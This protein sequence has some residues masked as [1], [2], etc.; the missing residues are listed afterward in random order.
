MFVTHSVY[1][2]AYLSSRIAVMSARPGCIVAEI[3][4]ESPGPRAKDFRTS[5]R[6]AQLCA[7]ISR[8]LLDQTAEDRL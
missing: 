4:G 3:E 5:A 1:E 6:Y 2:S 8:V 7:Q